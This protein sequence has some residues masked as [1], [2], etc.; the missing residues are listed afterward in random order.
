[1]SEQY[2]VNT[3]TAAVALAA[4]TAKT[5]IELTTSATVDNSLIGFDISFD[6][7]SSTA[8]P[9][10]IDLCSY[11]A[12]GTGT[13]ATPTLMGPAGRGS[14]TTAKVNDSVEPTTP[15]II[16]SFLVSP[17]AGFSYQWPLGREVDMGV[18]KVYGLR[19]TAPAAVNCVA[20]LYFE[21]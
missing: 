3:G 16:A 17:T 1:M 2:V 10:R 5:V 7:A 18:S 15:A 4:A 11:A 9:V 19:A 20:N 14:V 13:A 6:G 12:T 21:E 8:V